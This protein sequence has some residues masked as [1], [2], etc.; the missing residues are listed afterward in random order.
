MNKLIFTLVFFLLRL[1]IN[2]GTCFRV[3]QRQPTLLGLVRRAG[4]RRLVVTA[5]HFLLHGAVF[6]QLLAGEVGDL[7]E[8]A[9]LHHNVGL[10]GVWQDCVLRDDLWARGGDRSTAMD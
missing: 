5:V 10:A 6:L 2:I 9:G 1:I 4:R 3:S 7:Q 8:A